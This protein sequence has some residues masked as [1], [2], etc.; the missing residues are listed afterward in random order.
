MRSTEH[1]VRSESGEHR[2]DKQ[3]RR[4]PRETS[5]NCGRHTSPTC[6]KH[7]AAGGE[8][9]SAFLEYRCP[10]RVGHT[11]LVTLRAH[12]TARTVFRAHHFFFPPPHV[13]RIDSF[14]PSLLLATLVA[15]QWSACSILPA[16]ACACACACLCVCL[17]VDDMARSAPLATPRCPCLGRRRCSAAWRRRPWPGSQSLVAGICAAWGVAFPFAPLPPLLAGVLTHAAPSETGIHCGS[18]ACVR[19]CVRVSVCTSRPLEAVPRCSRARLS[20]LP[21]DRELPVCKKQHTVCPPRPFSSY[22]M[23][24]PGVANVH[25]H[26][27]HFLFAGLCWKRVVSPLL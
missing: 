12:F 11:H 22:S 20:L 26:I 5:I 13:S 25:M 19:A 4:L 14:S 27:L 6:A 10:G 9:R 23:T 18:R 16:C 3:N 8:C 17:C 1:A 2:D 7:K 24:R 15:P 21:T